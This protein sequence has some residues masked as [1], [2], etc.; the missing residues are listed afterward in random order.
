MRAGAVHPQAP[1]TGVK[2]EERFSISADGRV[3]LGVW[4]AVI[5]LGTWKSEGGV[6]CPGVEGSSTT[7]MLKR[8]DKK[9]RFRGHRR[10]D[11]LDLD[12]DQ[13]PSTSDNEC[14]D[15]P[16]RT[17]SPTRDP[18]DLLDSDTPPLTDAQAGAGAMAAEVQDFQRLEADRL[19]E[20]KGHLE[21]ALL[22]KHFLGK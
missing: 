13:S 4:T 8:L 15:D 19:T 17:G 7:T 11:S 12:L 1:P 9:I 5:P 2:R 16:A 22:E 18:E 10:D 14:G 6:A 20:V 3:E 21:I